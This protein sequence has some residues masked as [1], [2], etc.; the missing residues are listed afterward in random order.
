M[1]RLQSIYITATLS[2]NYLLRP[3][4]SSTNKHACQINK[5]QMI[6]S[7][8][9]LP[10]PTQERYKK[11]MNLA[12]QLLRC[13]TE[14]FSA[15]KISSVSIPPNIHNRIESDSRPFQLPKD[16]QTKMTALSRLDSDSES[17]AG[18][19]GGGAADRRASANYSDT[20]SNVMY[21]V[22]PASESPPPGVCPFPPTAM[23]HSMRGVGKC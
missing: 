17:L 13:N 16:M 6:L 10:S 8:L 9:L 23:V 14:N 12:I 18:G 5:T 19:G 2:F 3:T 22:L 11:D 1:P 20:H 7:Y 21:R 15:P 4:K